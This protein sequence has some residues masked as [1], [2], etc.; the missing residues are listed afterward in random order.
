MPPAF[1][2]GFAALVGRPN[3]GKSTLINQIIG[4]KVAIVSDKPQTT[5]NRIQAIYTAEDFQIVF[6]DTPGIHKPADKLGEY[7]VKTA[8][9]SLPEVDL[10]LYLVDASVT[11]GRG[12]EYLIREVIAP[13]KSPV[14]LVPNKT[15]VAGKEKVLEL[16]VKATALHNFAEVVPVSALTGENLPELLKTIQEYLP[17]GPRYY[18]PEMVVD[19]PEEFLLAELIREQVLN[20]TR[21]EIP[22]AVAVEIARM[23][24]EPDGLMYIDAVLNVERDSQKGIIIGH[25]G[26]RIKEIGSK[27]RT[28]IEKLLGTKVFLELTVRV[29][30]NWRKKEWE[31]RNLGFDSK[32]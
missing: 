31:L 15:D 12:E 7:L 2:S 32:L 14:F 21:E 29:R 13:V 16:V 9:G 6:L 5:R 20:L 28:E 22:H 27:A 18:P 11:F 19:R 3:A 10:V 25:Q 8:T 26:Q 30:K 17:E 23:E 24:E 1:R 4:Q